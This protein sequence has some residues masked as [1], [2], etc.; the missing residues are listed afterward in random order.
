LLGL[1]AFQVFDGIV[2][3]KLLQLHQVRYGVDT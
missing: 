1:G 3:H 2:D